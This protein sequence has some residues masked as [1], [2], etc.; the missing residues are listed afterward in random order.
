MKS[1]KIDRKLNTK[2]VSLPVNTRRDKPSMLTLKKT[3]RM[4]NPTVRRMIGRRMTMM[5]RRRMMITTMGRANGRL[6]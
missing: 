4:G 6:R 3:M 5:M 2:L 1:L